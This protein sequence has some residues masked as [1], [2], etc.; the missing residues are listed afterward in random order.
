MEQRDHKPFL[1][2]IF[3]SI[4]ILFCW[5][6]FVAAPKHEAYQKQLDTYNQ[7][8]AVVKAKQK[9][10]AKSE[11]ETP[12]IPEVAPR[13]TISSP[14]LS[15]TINLKGAR[16]DDLILLNYKETNTAD[17]PNVHLLS[18]LD[19]KES[20][21]S[22]FVEFGWLSNQSNL[23]L[24]SKQT[25]WENI[26]EH[27]D[28]TPQTPL[29]L[30]W[31]SSQNV[32]FYID[33]SIDTNYMFTITK[34]V[35]NLNNNVIHLTPYGLINRNFA[36]TSQTASFVHEGP[37][38]VSDNVL[39]EY[40][41]KDIAEDGNVTLQ[42]HQGG[43][44]G[45]SDKY[46]FTALVPYNGSADKPFESKFSYYISQTYPRYQVDYTG[47]RYSVEPNQS[48]SDTTLFY[49]GSKKL[50]LL[51]DYTESY[52]IGLFDRAVDFGT[53]YFISKPIFIT[54]RTINHYVG[55]FG[56]AI[57]A[58]TILIKLLL[59]PLAHKSYVSMHQL[60]QFHPQIMELKERYA[61]NKLQ[62]NKEVMA[63]YKRE[64]INPAS[65]CLPILLQIPIFF[66]LYRVLY[67]TIEMRHAPFFGWIKDLSAPDPTSIFN[68]FGLLPFEVAPVFQL[69]VWPIILGI[70]MFIQQRINPPPT[71]PMQAKVMKLFPYL[72][73]FVL[74]RFAA[75]LV[76][77]YAWNNTLTILQQW[78]ITRKLRKH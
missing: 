8:V 54:L 21:K 67:I 1:I 66:A 49:A 72:F 5:Q 25:I 46:W 17:S 12:S 73:T 20:P 4:L 70:T 34:R 51:D 23:E 50:S 36:S 76:I 63:L 78:L 57:L 11:K 59:F 56:L 74:Y 69:G 47:G 61:D 60:K 30:T 28:L 13:I 10:L 33:I 37:V 14:S 6:Y 43:W 68:L 58:L 27:T 24:P 64:K 7:Q 35:E 77:Y 71:D 19:N 16:I 75:G 15:G 44:L 22:Y 31:V 39:K 45:F 65:G 9:K 48:I 40:S 38:G 53:L 3:L 62:L 18:H 2:T 32:H 26:S 52:H 29:T 55:N 42:H 41:F